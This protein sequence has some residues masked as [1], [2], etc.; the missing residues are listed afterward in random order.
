M[1]GGSGSLKGG[2]GK[3]R[4]GVGGTQHPVT[5][6]PWGGYRV[7]P[8]SDL[9]IRVGRPWNLLLL[10]VGPGPSGLSMYILVLLTRLFFNPHISHS[11]VG[12]TTLFHS[13]CRVA[14]LS[15]LGVD[16][17]SPILRS[18]DSESIKSDG[19]QPAVKRRRLS[20]SSQVNWPSLSLT[21]CLFFSLS[22]LTKQEIEMLRSVLDLIGSV[23]IRI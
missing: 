7:L 3:G 17:L 20:V 12:G 9:M 15:Q 19:D 22:S 10:L 14:E 1:E 5:C 13:F 2:G 11:D 21:S 4:W 16:L 23:R 8:W 18:S 6:P